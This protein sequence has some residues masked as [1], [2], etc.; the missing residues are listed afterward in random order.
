M[1]TP[2]TPPA[3]QG[4]WLFAN[5]LALLALRL[6]LGWTFTFHGSQKLFGAF[7]GPGMQAWTGIID[8]MHL[9]LL[10]A[11]AWAYMAAGGEFFGGILVLI[12]LLTRLA[13]LPIIVTMLVAI[14]SVTGAN[15]FGGSYDP[16]KGLQL[17]YEFN[18]ALIAMSVALLLSGAG[19]LSLDALLFKRNLWAH[20]P[21]PLDNPIKKT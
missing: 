19:L 3:R 4:N 13:T 5:S 14:V 7:N 12:G 11:S 16:V 17:G 15:G 18:L 20:G 6:V 8:S 21:Q 2:L 10:P 1:T 9:P